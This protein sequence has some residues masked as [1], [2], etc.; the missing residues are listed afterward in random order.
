MN[1]RPLALTLIQVVRHSACATGRMLVWLG[2]RL[3]RR[4][5][6][7]RRADAHGRRYQ[8][9][10]RDFGRVHIEGCTEVSQSAP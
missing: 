8:R 6:H 3:V 4:L 5:R 10:I 9:A 2:P 7:R 1:L